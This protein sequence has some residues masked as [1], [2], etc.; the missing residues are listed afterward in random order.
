[1]SSRRLVGPIE[2]T[3]AYVK[4]HGIE[5]IFIA[6]PM[7]SQPRIRKLLEDLRDTTASIHF[8]PDVFVFDMI[9][10]RIDTVGGMPVVTVC[11]SPFQGVAGIVKRASDVALATVA[12]L[13]TLP[14]MLPIAAA[15]RLESR[16]PVIFRQRRYGMD[17]REII[18]WKFRTMTVLEDGDATYRQVARNDERVTRVGRFL[19]RSSLDE[20]PQFFNVLQGR[21]SVVGPRP[22]A[23]AVNEQY[24][25][26]IPG[27][28][29]RHKIRPGI[30]GLAQ[31]N[32]YRG[33]DDLPGMQKR[34]EYDLLYLRNWSIGLDLRIVMQTVGVVFGDR[35][36]Y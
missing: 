19:R 22:H 13:M 4:A 3:A 12:L 30:T 16:G 34:V 15:I 33:G 26:L 1:M 31:V 2:H 9:Q 17:G 32:G 5:Q 25:K 28:M 27:Y 21:M 10:A 11:E 36:A 18:V 7:S 23:V 35:K 6:L 29:I 24:R 20:L 14:L 8:L